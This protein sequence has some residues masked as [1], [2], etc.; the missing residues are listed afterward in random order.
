MQVEQPTELLLETTRRQGKHNMKALKTKCM[1]PGPSIKLPRHS[2]L[3]RNNH[4][5]TSTAVSAR[6]ERSVR[7]APPDKENIYRATSSSRTTKT[8]LWLC[9]H[10][11]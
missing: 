5:E 1:L 4:E 10:T 3:E 2:T 8:V 6:P 7:Y 11:R 9:R